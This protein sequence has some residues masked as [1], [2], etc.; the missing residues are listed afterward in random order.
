MY[1]HQHLFAAAKSA[2]QTL[3][4]VNLTNLSLYRWFM[5]T[6]PHRGEARCQALRMWMWHHPVPARVCGC[7]SVH[8]SCPSTM[9]LPS[10]QDQ[11]GPATASTEPEHLWAGQCETPAVTQPRTLSPH[12]AQRVPGHTASVPETS[13][14]SL[15]I[16]HYQYTADLWITVCSVQQ[17]RLPPCCQPGT[18]V[19]VPSPCHRGSRARIP[20]PH[21]LCCRDSQQH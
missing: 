3:I 4:N 16:F 19:L 18:S 14:C 1:Q 21:H 20:L 6:I 15:S 2:L 17:P 5:V 10:L 11:Q 9:H 8:S 7:R 13:M 12:P